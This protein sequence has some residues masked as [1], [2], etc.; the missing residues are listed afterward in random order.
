MATYRKT[1]GGWRAEIAVRGARESKVFATKA[2][3]AAWAAERET[4]LRRQ[5]ET[6]IVTGKTL[7]D[8]ATRYEKEVSV[9]KRGHMWE[10]K[11]LAWI[12]A[13]RIDEKNLGSR[14]LVELTPDLLGRFRDM[15]LA[16]TPG[17]PPIT[18]ASFNRDLN[19]LSHVLRTA[20]REWKWIPESPTKDVRRPKNSLPR[21]R[22]ISSDE[23]ERLCTNLNF[24]FQPI[25]SKKQA[26]GAAFLFAIETAMRES[27]ICGLTKLDIDGPVAHLRMTKNGTARDVPLSKKAREILSCLPEPENDDSPL[28]MLT[29]S[30]LS[31]LFRVARDQCMID[32]LT[33]HDTR[34]EAITRL[35]K[36]L[37]V[38]DLAR[39]VGHKDLRMLQIYYN[40][41]AASM[42]ARLD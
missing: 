34:H 1:G 8:A 41:T 3:A 42:A 6:G 2:Q 9:H 7:A 24:N 32:G 30:S 10:A 37:S 17:I 22:L 11:R 18:G 13:Y 28:F 14:P 26:V 27:E 5:A 29:A 38:L 35:A 31:T 15:R 36:K 39:M 12:C 40:E 21:D 23:I 4:V 33:F 20:A 16:G 19:L 25:S